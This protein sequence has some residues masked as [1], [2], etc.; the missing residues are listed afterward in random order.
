MSSWNF[1]EK[2]GCC[3]TT[4]LTG[5]DRIADVILKL[6]YTPQMNN[7]HVKL[8]KSSFQF[9][10]YWTIRGLTASL[11]IIAALLPAI[12]ALS[13][14]FWLDGGY[15]WRE[16][17]LELGVAC[18]TLAIIAY[19]TF[20]LLNWESLQAKRLDE[21][22]HDFRLLIDQAVDMVF[23]ISSEGRIIE[24]NQRA[25]DTLGYTKLE[26]TQLSILDLDIDCYL[27][28]HPKLVKLMRSGDNVTYETRYRSKEGKRIPVEC[29]ARTANWLEKPHYIEF[30]SDISQRRKVEKEIDESRDALEKTRNLLE[31]RIAQHS[32]EIKKQKQSREMAERYAIS[33]QNYL[34]KLIDSMPSGIIAVDEQYRVM[35]WNIEAEKMTS[36][37][38]KMAI[39]EQLHNL[40]PELDSQI[41]K[42]TTHSDLLD[43]NIN[44]QFKTLI[45]KEMRT[46]DVMIYP[47]FTLREEEQSTLR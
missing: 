10:R 40:F 11:I 37:S 6:S 20:H 36:V 19:P 13:I 46:L 38:A 44:F 8:H 27:H 17:A 24:A 43:K 25:C 4:I 42:T 32:S 39:G 34:E 21:T 35:Q 12:S 33:M 7:L 3:S 26:L 23:L 29:R 45:H 47:I 14:N 28:R 31:L 2:D 22:K 18:L 1:G 15:N 30:V 41:K 9:A 16:V 5:I